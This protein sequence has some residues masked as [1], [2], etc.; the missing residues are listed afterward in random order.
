MEQFFFFLNMCF[1]NQIT[2]LNSRILKFDDFF[3]QKGH[4]ILIFLLDKDYSYLLAELL[5]SI[6]VICRCTFEYPGDL[7]KVIPKICEPIN[8]NV[9]EEKEIMLRIK[10]LSHFSYNTKS[11]EFFRESQLFELINTMM[12]SPFVEKL[13]P[14]C[15]VL[16]ANISK[17]DNIMRGFMEQESLKMIILFSLKSELSL[18]KTVIR[19]IANITSHDYFKQTLLT[20]MYFIFF[21]RNSSPVK[22]VLKYFFNFLRMVTNLFKFIT[23][24]Y[25]TDIKNRMDLDI[26]LNSV[27]I[28]FL[29][30]SRLNYGIVQALAK[31]KLVHKLTDMVMVNIS[32]QIFEIYHL[33]IF[34]IIQTKFG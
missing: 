19:L 4:E 13:I 14:D 23:R 18:K 2:F 1:L 8:L 12:K 10:I 6:H 11:I 17:D 26:T 22:N 16:L 34:R 7:L 27:L 25:Y 31:E 32:F 33:F 5:E 20:K 9:D 28:S 21:F 24:S 29:N 3:K 15:C 30:L